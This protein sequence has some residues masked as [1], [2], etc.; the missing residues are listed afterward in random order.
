MR[1]PHLGAERTNLS[2]RQP[3]FR[4]LSAVH[5]ARFLRVARRH[6]IGGR[7]MLRLSPLGTKATQVTKVIVGARGSTGSE[8]INS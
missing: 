5:L 8:K 2:A 4:R 3:A 6:Q 7:Q 1:Q